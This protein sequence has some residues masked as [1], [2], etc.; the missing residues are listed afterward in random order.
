MKKE[1]EKNDSMDIVKIDEEKQKIREEDNLNNN[2]DKEEKKERSKFS[3]EGAK[4]PLSLYTRRVFDISLLNQYL[5][6]N[7][8]SGICGSVNLGNTCYM[9]SSIA[10]LSNCTE[11]PTFKRILG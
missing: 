4:L 10:C 9:N 8:S 3:L 11:F 1:Q 6:E 2:Q 5:N 7:S